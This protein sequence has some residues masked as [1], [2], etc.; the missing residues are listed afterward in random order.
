MSAS[1]ATRT[2]GL[3]LTRAHHY[4]DAPYAALPPALLILALLTGDVVTLHVL[5][6]TAGNDSPF[7]G[8]VLALVIPAA[9]TLVAHFAA[10]AVLRWL[11]ERRPAQLAGA[12]ILTAIWGAFIWFGYLF[13]VATVAAL[14]SAVIGPS[15][16]VTGTAPVTA[17]PAP[18]DR[19]LA[20][21][22]SLFLVLTGAATAALAAAEY[23]PLQTRR[24]S[25][26]RRRQRLAWKIR[27]AAARHAR[28]AAR[29]DRQQAYVERL[30][31]QL[32]DRLAQLDA[33]ATDLK[34]LVRQ[35]VAVASGSPA[36]VTDLQ[37]LN[38]VPGT[39][40]PATATDAESEVEREASEGTA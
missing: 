25:V 19:P 21:L 13:R 2:T 38:P 14:S 26:A 24:R 20:L 3:R 36:T 35:R 32:A 28:P 29:R 31:D 4:A 39:A 34:H 11:H 9:L 7:V 30:P 8:W 40:A 27:Y 22:L 12:L 18:S 23:D 37:F 10:V 15:I 17:G 5:I 33:R 1:S 6:A 16:T